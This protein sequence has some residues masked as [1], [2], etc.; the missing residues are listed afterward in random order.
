MEVAEGEAGWDELDQGE[1]LLHVFNSE[2][3]MLVVKRIVDR[4]ES[5]AQA[6]TQG[7]RPLFEV[8]QYA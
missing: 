6:R 7:L 3:D 8:V 4:L 1:F 5:R 2:E